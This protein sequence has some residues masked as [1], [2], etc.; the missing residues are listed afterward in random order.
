MAERDSWAVTGAIDVEEARVALGALWTPSGSAVKSK[1]GIRPG[2]GSRTPGTVYASA[3]PDGNV[4]IA[5]FQ[6]V[7]QTSR[8]TVGGAYVLT[9]DADKAIN[10]LSTPA[11]STNPRND[12]IIA[13][14]SDAFYGDGSNVMVIRQ[15]VGTPSGTPADPSTASYPDH[16]KL[17]R[18][19][20]NASATSISGSNLTDLRPADLYTVA[21]GGILPVPSQ[22]VRDA[23]TGFYAG[24]AIWRTDRKWVEIHDGTA[25]RVQGVPVVTSVADLSAITNPAAGAVAF[26]SADDKFYR[27]NGTSW[28]RADWNAPWGIIGGRSWPLGTGQSFGAGITTTE[29]ALTGFDST[30]VSTINGRRYRLTASTRAV[31]SV[32]AGL[33]LRI[34]DTNASGTV[35]G[36]LHIDPVGTQ[37]YTHV[38]IG[39]FDAA[40]DASK[41]FVLT[42]ATLGSGS[43]DFPRDTVTPP[44]F[45]VE[46]IG[47]AANLT[48]TA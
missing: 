45:E 24:Y 29:L 13:H 21:V 23:L 15:V 34:R 2:P 17:A 25:W 37:G 38:V 14:Q 39:R 48:A 12:L 36:Y 18:V 32:T 3:T 46:D 9:L 7:L 47:P 6:G 26:N 42:A 41:T 28:R 20:V 19:R 35:R 5:A 30:A 10:V 8:A 43:A 44:F 16:I 22:T 33:E 27:H 40:A 31:R 1:S 4:N 11:D